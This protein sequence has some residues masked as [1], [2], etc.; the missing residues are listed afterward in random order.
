M[1]GLL[2]VSESI[3]RLTLFIGRQVRWL[4]LVAVVVS[5]ANAVSARHSIQAQ[6]PGWSCRG[7]FSAPCSC[8]QQPMCCRKTPMCGSMP[9][10]AIF[11]CAS[12]IGLTF[13]DI[14]SFCCRFACSWSGSVFP[15]SGKPSERRN[16]T[17]CRR[18]SVWPSN[19]SC[20]A[21]LRFCWRRPF[22]NHQALGGDQGAP[23]D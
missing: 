1:E 11:P 10:P 15:I 23:H 5:A 14:S 8:W 22:G 7:I 4:I 19:F 6:M 2:R 16:V 20:L 12:A 17:Q 9:F 13:S 18:F 21:G 3:D